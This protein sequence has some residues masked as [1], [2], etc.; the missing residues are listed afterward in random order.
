MFMLM[1]L[2]FGEP[3]EF[4]HTEDAYDPAQVDLEPDLAYRGMPITDPNW[5]PV[6]TGL[7]AP[8]RMPRVRSTA[9]PSCS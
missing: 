8:S 1:P 4:V 7:G 2:A 9:P 3:T 5:E 6:N